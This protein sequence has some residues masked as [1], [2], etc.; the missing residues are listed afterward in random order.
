ME[1]AC[2]VV[3]ARSI[4]DF[5]RIA[6]IRLIN[7]PSD[8]AEALKDRMS[9]IDHFLERLQGRVQAM[10]EGETVRP[11]LPGTSHGRSAAEERL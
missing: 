6:A 10:V 9:Q 4:S 11:T 5:A 7:A 8:G 3:G 1:K 2:D